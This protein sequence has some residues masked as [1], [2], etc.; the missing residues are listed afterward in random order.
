MPPKRA[1]SP[2]R[3]GPPSP[4][5]GGSSSYA[6]TLAAIERT[7]LPK[8]G[9]RPPTAEGTNDKGKEF[10]AENA[11]KAGVIV[12]PSGLQYRVLKASKQKDVI[13]PKMDSPCDVHYIGTLID[14]TEFDKSKKP[15][16]KGPANFAPNKVIQAWTI[17]MQLMGEGDKWQLFAPSELCYGDAG[18]DKFIAPGDVLIFEMELLKVNGQSK[19]KPVRPERFGAPAALT[20]AAPVAAAPVA[21]APPPPK[22][23]EGL[24]GGV[25]E[26]WPRELVQPAEAVQQPHVKRSKS[27][28]EPPAIATATELAPPLPTAPP[29][30]PGD[31]VE[32]AP[33][34]T[35]AG[36][37][38]SLSAPTAKSAEQPTDEEATNRAFDAGVDTTLEAMG[39][40]LSKLQVPT[41]RQ[42]L[43]DLGLPTSGRKE[44]LTERLIAGAVPAGGEANGMCEA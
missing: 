7:S 18:R 16:A 41:L 23:V 20:A 38:P 12:L 31:D 35:T 34:N 8:P 5:K 1:A 24:D 26:Q 9:A 19:P 28:A 11:T 30:V 44:V 36:A 22:A 13:S 15:G 10:L 33:R 2:A 25:E 40:M 32:N 14:G 3:G 4:A 17:A 6:S 39:Q 37:V 27:S 29:A 42:A 21:A 43:C